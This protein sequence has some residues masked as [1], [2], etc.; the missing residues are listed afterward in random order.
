MAH[1]TKLP[2]RSFVVGLGGGRFDNLD[3]V[4]KFR[5]GLMEFAPEMFE[6]L[7][8]HPLKLFV[9]F[10]ESEPLAHIGPIPNRNGALSIRGT[11]VPLRTGGE[12]KMARRKSRITG[13]K[14]SGSQ[15]SITA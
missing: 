5:Q 7:L 15:E 2:S 13:K 8:V 9:V 4:T 14:L 11:F 3:T 1:H 12:E 6:I 10:V